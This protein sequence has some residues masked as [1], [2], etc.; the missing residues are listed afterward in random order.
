[1]PTIKVDAGV[2]NGKEL[3][4]YP[5]NEADLPTVQESSSSSAAPARLTLDVNLED[6]IDEKATSPGSK[7]TFKVSKDVKREGKTLVPK[8][9]VINGRVTRVSRQSYR[10]GETRKDYYI[11]GIQLDIN[12]AC[13]MTSGTR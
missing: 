3:F 12:G 5:A 9:A 8:G 6:A 2:I 13:S 10:V 1:M 11:V 4:A 7:V